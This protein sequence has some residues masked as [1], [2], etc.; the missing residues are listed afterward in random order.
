MKEWTHKPLLHRVGPCEY[1]NPA[2]TLYLLLEKPPLTLAPK[3][4][5]KQPGFFLLSTV[6]LRVSPP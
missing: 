3:M 5:Q 6:A 4:C 2:A 1:E